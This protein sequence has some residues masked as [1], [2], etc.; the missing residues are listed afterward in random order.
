MR[1]VFESI[2]DIEG[3]EGSNPVRSGG[4]SSA[5]LTWETPPQLGE[6][7]RPVFERWHLVS[8]ASQNK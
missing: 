7:V 3:T 4:E 8:R 2:I 5:N 1:T 6:L